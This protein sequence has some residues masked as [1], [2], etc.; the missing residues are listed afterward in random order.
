MLPCQ[1]TFMCATTI[2]KQLPPAKWSSACYPVDTASDGL[3][4]YAAKESRSLE[5]VLTVPRADRE[6][7]N[8]FWLI[9][10]R[11]AAALGQLA[12]ISVTKFAIGIDVAFGSLCAVIG[13]EVASN[14]AVELWYRYAIRH[15][16]KLVQGPIAERLIGAILVFDLLVLTALLF[17]AGGPANP[18][19]IFYIVSISLAAAVLRQRWAWALTVLAAGCFGM[20]FLWHVPVAALSH[21]GPSEPAA[22]HGHGHHEHVLDA[23]PM[24]LHLRG[25]LVAFTG[26]ACFVAYF[27]TRMRTE[28]N[29]RDHQL[30]EAER[31]KSKAERLD[32]LVTLAAG[33][34]HELATPLATI[35]VIARELEFENEASDDSSATNDEVRAICAEVERCREILA[36]LSSQAGTNIGESWSKF[37][38]D[39]LIAS[40]ESEAA[41]RGRLQVDLPADLKAIDLRLPRQAIAQSLR[42][43]IRNAWEASLPSGPIRL[44]VARNGYWLSIDVE[45]RGA[46][47]APDI[48]ERLGE[49]FLTSRPHGSGLGL[50]FCLARRVMDQL[51]GRL[52]ARSEL[53]K[54]TT[55]TFVLPMRAE[56]NGP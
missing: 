22:Q 3:S 19:S 51:G 2:D 27:V 44:T 4:M 40:I 45:D 36:S 18:F 21:H 35:A 32:S 23:E 29:Q 33:A 52:E 41:W 20:L 48:F 30:A 1:A 37:S 17:F 55:V 46:G 49:P 7:I 43:I 53:G 50:G 11:W 9:R 24:A 16:P 14:T 12:T 5:N 26:A 8:L 39:E 34:A 31:R 56:A 28:L 25:M 10:L 42:S 15:N 54:G 47:I 13:L 6:Q 38:V